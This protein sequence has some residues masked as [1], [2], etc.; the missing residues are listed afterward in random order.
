MTKL[1]GIL[2]ITPD[3]FS[4]G[5][6]HNSK[7]TAIEH[8]KKLIDNGFDVIDIGAESTRPNAKPIT[9]EKEIC[10]LDGIIKE[11]YHITQSCEKEI[12]ISLD[13][14]NYKTIKK[15][16]DYIDIIN[17]VSGLEDKRII[18]IGKERGKKLVLMHNLG[19]PSDPN[20]MFDE[21]LD[22]ID[23]LSEW[24]KEKKK[25]LSKF[26][27]DQKNIIFDPGIGF[28]KG[29]F[30]N[31]EI[32][33]RVNELKKFGFDLLIGHSRKRF[34]DYFSCDGVDLSCSRDQKTRA[35]NKIM[36]EK[37]ISYLRFHC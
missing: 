22:I 23:L 2:N 20:N 26:N 34:L 8:V 33:N 6:K 17:D 10:R 36:I 1:F 27:L 31:I 16:I 24:I 11:I 37:G 29:H 13:S 9:S 3:S 28:G 19:V 32:I 21:N 14:R 5:G 15:Y 18:N 4:D 30:H 7:I 25:I 12:K 35:I